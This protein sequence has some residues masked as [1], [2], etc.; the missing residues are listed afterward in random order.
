MEMHRSKLF[1]VLPLLGLLLIL[2]AAPSAAAAGAQE[3]PENVR[4]TIER[5]FPDA[6]IR[7][8]SEEIWKQKAATKVELT[9]KD[10]TLY[11]V[12]IAKDGQLLKVKDKDDE[13]PLI[14]GKLSIALAVLA[15]QDIYKGVDS[16]IQPAPFL[17]YE[18]GPF[19]I[20]T[21]NG[22]DASLRVFGN[23]SFSASLKG[24][25]LFDEGYNADD[26][27]FLKGMDELETLYNAGL[28]FEG[29][30]GGWEVSLE[31]LQDVSG[32]HDGQ[33]VELAVEYQWQA[34]GF[35][36]MPSVSITW[37]SKDTV[38]YFYG[39]STKEANAE[40]PAYSPGSSYE[41]GAELM[42][43]RPLFGN[44]TA[45]G[46]CEI[47]SFAKDITDSPLVEDDY[48]ISGILGVMYTF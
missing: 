14:G 18:K 13:L 22:F 43:Q 48:E 23:K 37:L 39:V 28:G 47:A 1:K 6:Q 21:R 5:E 19:E 12:H 34:A 24:S 9:T 40:R 16:E 29:Q 31:A 35:E 38:E 33:E 8:I 42:I 44:F 36:F 45:V 17:R 10:G 46:I 2:N 30:F 26:S 4:E 41:I 32:E 27:D 20:M 11:E 7:K 25:L 3:L 15:E